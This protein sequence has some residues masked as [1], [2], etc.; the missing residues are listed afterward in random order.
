MRTPARF[1]ASCAFAVLL[2]AT[3]ACAQKSRPG[4]ANDAPGWPITNPG[5]GNGRVV[6]DATLGVQ[7]QNND[8]TAE[9]CSLWMV[10]RTQQASVDTATLQVPAKAE[11]EYAKACRDLSQ[12][13]LTAAESHLRK[14]IQQYPRYAAA[15]VLMGQ[16]LGASN[17]INEARTACAKATAVDS[18]YTPAY[19][20][21][22]DVAAR[23][24]VWNQALEMADR[25][26]ALAPMYDPYAY[27]YSAIAEFHLGRLSQAQRHASRAVDADPFHRIPQV[28]LLLAEIYGAEQDF[29]DATIELRAY[30]KVAPNSPD[31]AA[32]RE[33]LAELEGR[34]A[35]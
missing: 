1:H 17:Q 30:L 20:C 31:A 13:K 18:G 32:A 34:D 19:L 6:P 14:A 10:P 24:Q 27:F 12:H 3:P 9:S 29:H 16:V 26:L 33:K 22:A 35:K 5:R 23:Q 21:L 4:N 2:V 11:R 8:A 7:N 28:H 15:W 25:G